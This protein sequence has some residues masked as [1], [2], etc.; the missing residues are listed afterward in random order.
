MARP[1]PA[2]DVSAHLAEHGR[3]VRLPVPAGRR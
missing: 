1:A 3:R 2:E